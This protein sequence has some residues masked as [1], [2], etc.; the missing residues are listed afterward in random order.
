[1]KEYDISDERYRHYTIYNLT[2]ILHG[3][4][5]DHPQ[6]L[7]WEPGH[8]FHRIFDGSI[9]TLAPAPGV[10]KDNDGNIVGYVELVWC[11]KDR[12]KP[13]AF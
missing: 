6:L 4:H 9:V 8:Q 7:V 2:G 13:I 11:P 1:M 10:L 12:N 5:I 3:I